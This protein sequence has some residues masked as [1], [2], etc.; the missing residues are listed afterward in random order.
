L[1]FF[2]LSVVIRHERH[3]LTGTCLNGNSDGNGNYRC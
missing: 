2:M 3:R 1:N